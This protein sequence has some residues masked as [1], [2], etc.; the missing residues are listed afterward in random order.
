MKKLRIKTNGERYILERIKHSLVCFNGYITT[1][2]LYNSLN[3]KS[4]SFG[5][6]NCIMKN[7]IE[8]RLSI[9][10]TI[11]QDGKS[12]ITLIKRISNRKTGEIIYRKVEHIEVGRDN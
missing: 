3:L 5:V 2:Y 7:D 1:M 12:R 9:Y 4:K 11:E 10:Y 8:K 6:K